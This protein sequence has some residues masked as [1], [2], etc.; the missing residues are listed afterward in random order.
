MLSVIAKALCRR[1]IQEYRAFSASRYSLRLSSKQTCSDRQNSN[2]SPTSLS[3]SLSLLTSLGWQVW[4]SSSDEMPPW[5]MWRGEWSSHSSFRTAAPWS[6]LP[7]HLQV[8]VSTMILLNTSTPTFTNG[9]GT[10]K[11][12]NVEKLRQRVRLTHAN[13]ALRDHFRIVTVRKELGIR[14]LIQQDSDLLNTFSQHLPGQA[15]K[16]WSQDVF[17]QM[18]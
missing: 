12:R 1:L 15:G 10:I 13:F 8:W 7:H 5:A 9:S 17:N 14:A 6:H 11:K 2:C 3:T 4:R 18:S 16:P